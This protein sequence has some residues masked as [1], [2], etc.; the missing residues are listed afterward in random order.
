MFSL[1]KGIHHLPSLTGPL[2]DFEL[3]YRRRSFQ[4][5]TLHLLRYH[6]CFQT[7]IMTYNLSQALVSTH[8]PTS[9]Y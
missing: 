6:T 2:T 4:T 1:E 7:L 3:F 9:T 5:F 8:L